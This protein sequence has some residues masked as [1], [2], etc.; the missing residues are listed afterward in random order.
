MNPVTK[1]TIMRNSYQVAAFAFFV[2]SQNLLEGE[3]Q[4]TP[5]KI[6]HLGDSFSAGNGYR[7][8]LGLADYYGPFGCKR[9]HFNWG[10]RYVATLSDEF[11]V[12]YINRACSGAN[13]INLVE[14]Q[15]QNDDF[16]VDR[17][18]RI[19]CP[20]SQYPDEEYYEKEGIFTCVRY[21]VPQ[22]DILDETVDLVLLTVGGN[23]ANFVGV[24]LS[25][26][27][28]GTR[29][30][31]ECRDELDQGLLNIRDTIQPQLTEFLPRLAEKMTA[32]GESQPHGKV[33]VV[34]YPN[35]FLDVPYVLSD[36]EVSFDV[37]ERIRE[38]VDLVDEVQ[39]AAVEATNAAVGTEFALFFNKTKGAFA[40]HEIDPEPFSRNPDRWLLEIEGVRFRDYFHLNTAGHIGLSEVVAEDGSFGIPN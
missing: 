24:A 28:P 6:V 17:M 38:L 27:V 29:D 7:N 33:V 37:T 18:P 9:S 4:E 14:R 8:E 2:L 10:E 3:A 15:R 30:A 16:L 40:G 34:S 20:R 11:N 35:L 36:E 31:S 13:V 32:D 22:I 25:C 26:I 21:Q 23:D 1:S 39:I 12:T 5:L 19:F